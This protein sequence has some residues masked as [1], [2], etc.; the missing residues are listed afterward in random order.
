MID[1]MKH[2]RLDNAMLFIRWLKFHGKI[3]EKEF[4]D[5]S[6]QLKLLTMDR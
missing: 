6:K 4:K 5:L 2:C 1:F 3:N